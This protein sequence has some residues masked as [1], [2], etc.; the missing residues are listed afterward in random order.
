MNSITINQ[1]PKKIGF[2]FMCYD[3]IENIDFWNIFFYDIPKNEYGIYIHTKNVNLKNTL[4]KIDNCYIL[5][6]CIKTKWADISL[7]KASNLLFETAFN[8][9]CDYMLLL[10]SDTI[11]LHNF[12]YLQS[13]I[14]SRREQKVAHRLKIFTCLLHILLFLLM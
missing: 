14:V 6:N 7:V 1:Q 12:E 3:F 10:S 4:L 8:D 5:N 9:G 13:R 11:S 2:C